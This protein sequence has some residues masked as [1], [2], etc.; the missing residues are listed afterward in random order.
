MQ[1]AELVEPGRAFSRIPAPVIAPAIP[2]PVR[3]GW[4]PVVGPTGI[5]AGGGGG[6]Q[7]YQVGGAGSG[8]WNWWR[9]CWCSWFS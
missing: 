1:W 5:F 7:Y 8:R 4:T 2:A 3:P 6:S 9:W